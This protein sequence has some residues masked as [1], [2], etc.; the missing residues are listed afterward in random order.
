MNYVLTLM[1]PAQNPSMLL[2]SSNLNVSNV[3]V[4]LLTMFY[5]FHDFLPSP[6]LFDQSLLYYYSLYHLISGKVNFFSVSLLEN[7]FVVLMD[8][9]PSIYLGFTGYVI[10][11]PRIVVYSSTLN[12]SSSF[13]CIYVHNFYNSLFIHK[14]FTDTI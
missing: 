1:K 3:S 7:Y 12:Y 5:D 8:F 2:P 10:I 11:R 6:I 14:C 9:F 13:W 4:I